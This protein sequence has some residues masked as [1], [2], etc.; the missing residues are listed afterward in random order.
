[1]GA[2]TSNR[3][4]KQTSMTFSPDG[5]IFAFWRTISFNKRMTGVIEATV[6][7]RFGCVSQN[8]PSDFFLHRTG[9]PAVPI[10]FRQDK[11]SHAGRR[12]PFILAP[13]TL[14]RHRSSTDQE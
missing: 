6:V 4:N 1:M 7:Q 9:V 10:I 14:N 12:K 5:S 3:R 2:R 13:L 8:P 11:N